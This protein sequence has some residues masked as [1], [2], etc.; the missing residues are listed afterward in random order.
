MAWIRATSEDVMS[1]F[2]PSEQSAIGGMVED[3]TIDAIV[4]RTTMEVRDAVSSGG[5]PLDSDEDSIP[6]GLVNAL[7]SIARWRL[8]VSAPSFKQLQTEER[9]DLYKDALEKLNLIAQR[10]IMPELPPAEV[11]PGFANWNSEVKFPMRTHPVPK[12]SGSAYANPNAPE[13]IT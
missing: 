6:G 11:P 2:T 13:D 9:H 1:E 5:Y 10:K 4:A 8:L 12:Q 3:N 7:I